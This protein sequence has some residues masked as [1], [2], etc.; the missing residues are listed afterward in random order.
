[1]AAARGADAAAGDA[2]PGCG[3]TSAPRERAH[4]AAS[5]SSYTYP[6]KCGTEP[7]SLLLFGCRA[8]RRHGRGW[9]W[10]SAERCCQA[11]RI[12]LHDEVLALSLCS[13]TEQ[14]VALLF[15]WSAGTMFKKA[16]SKKKPFLSFPCVFPAASKARAPAPL[17]RRGASSHQALGPTTPARETSKQN[18]S[19]LQ[20]PFQPQRFTG[21]ITHYFMNK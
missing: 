18:P 4:P 1:M 3:E 10:G 13:R 11:L 12:R 20:W 19:E 7:C 17:Q 5:L 2:H 6:G 8:P 15:P 21:M 14:E 9:R 16:F